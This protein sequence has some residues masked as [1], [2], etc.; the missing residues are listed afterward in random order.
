[1]SVPKKHLVLNATRMLS[2]I[3]DG[4]K[5][6]G[7]YAIIMLG[8]LDN[9]AGSAVL[10]GTV[11]NEAVKDACKSILEKLGDGNLIINP[12]EKN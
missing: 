11:N 12:Y 3:R 7:C 8:N 9:L 6:D 4:V 1:M 2:Q 5:A 10:V